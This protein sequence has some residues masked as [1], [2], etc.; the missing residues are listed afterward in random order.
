M[1]KKRTKNKESTAHKVGDTE[2]KKT[3]LT[4]KARKHTCQGEQITR[5]QRR[6]RIRHRQMNIR[7]R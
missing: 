7:R 5:R 2:G 3:T 6:N 4:K 1:N